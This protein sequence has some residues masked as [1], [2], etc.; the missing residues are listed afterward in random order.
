MAL[1]LGF[2]S[3][4]SLCYSRIL[5]TYLT[6]YSPTAIGADLHL[7]SPQEPHLHRPRPV[8]R[9]MSASTTRWV[10]GRYGNPTLLE[11]FAELLDMPYPRPLKNNM[12]LM[13][14]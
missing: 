14:T 2:D 1:K 7:N 11:M 5:I 8:N 3:S 9:L 6:W 13:G 10:S 4:N 12:H